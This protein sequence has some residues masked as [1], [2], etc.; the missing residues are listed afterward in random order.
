MNLLL[1]NPLKM[2]Y[3]KA[4]QIPTLLEILLWLAFLVFM[5]VKSFYFQ[6]STAVN[7]KPFF[8]PINDNMLLATLTTV[9]LVMAFIHLFFNRKRLSALLIMNVVLSLVLLSDT[10]YYRYYYTAITV[11]VLYQIGLVGSLK[12]SIAGLLRIK[13]LIYVV[14]FPLIIALMLL[15][16][17]NLKIKP[18]RI[19]P[20]KK[21]VTAGIILAISFGLFQWTYGKSSPG[22][23]SYDNNYV[24]NSLGVF[25]FHY[26]DVKKFATEHIFVDNKMTDEDKAKIE[27]YYSNR[28]ESGEKYKGAARGKNLIVVQLEAIQQFVINRKFNGKEI[29]PVLNKFINDS[30]YFENFYYQIGGGNTSD[31]EFLSNTSLYPLS[32]GAVYFRYPSNTYN[33][34][35]KLLKEQ[36][37]ATYASHANN[38]SFW[39]RT[40]M[41]KSYGFD[42]FISSKNLV[43]DEYL[44]WGLGDSSFLKQTM[45]KLDTSKPFYGF[46]VT[47]ASHYPF[48]YFEDY[49]EFN[50]GKY[51]D[52]F[53]GDYIKGASYVDKSLGL[54]FEDLKRRGLYD[55]S[56]IVIYGD[57]Y[58]IPKDQSDELKA[59]MDYKDTPVNWMK[60]QK[61][62]CFIR[63]PGMD[64]KGPQKITAGEIDIQPTVANLLGI[65][66]PYALGKDLF[67]TDKGYAVLRNRS[68]VTDDFIY[69]SAENKVYSHSGKE[70]NKAD[71]A[72]LIG[73]YQKQLE[74]SDLIL[75]KNAL[76][77]LKVLN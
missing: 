6:F 35:A 4:P 58:A 43:L 25:Y 16:K 30:A 17:Y 9:L 41:Y 19:R 13:D 40:E 12:E 7:T 63:F 31:A 23:F 45:E 46:F 14:D 74:I 3:L 8:S 56:V 28:P 34:T 62:P 22:G 48:N 38:P 42:K 1:K 51:E 70:L 39:N 66:N 69:L 55:D 32:E 52:T 33:S 10:I 18:V 26:Y 61:T 37:Y 65:E 54:F 73:E 36:G 27:E 21:L 5:M 20:G 15:M 64:N 68:V 53:I 29:T 59:V 2:Y 11:P 50:V 72:G 47:L 67:N 60:L 71:F 44:G 24:I 57:H 76:N 49:N 77:A 75:K